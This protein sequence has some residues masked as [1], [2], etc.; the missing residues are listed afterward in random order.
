M[1]QE[2]LHAVADPRP[3]AYDS[4]QRPGDTRNPPSPQN[5]SH[6]T[7]TTPLLRGYKDKKMQT[8]GQWLEEP[9]S[10]T[11]GKGRQLPIAFPAPTLLKESQQE[12]LLCSPPSGPRNPEA[13]EVCSACVLGARGQRQGSFCRI[14][15]IYATAECV[16]PS[17]TPKVCPSLGEHK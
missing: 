10:L 12:A 17:T 7:P 11:L 15:N 14:I 5:N 3:W 2:V 9:R 13:G 4:Q 1:N 6:S 8:K 16:S